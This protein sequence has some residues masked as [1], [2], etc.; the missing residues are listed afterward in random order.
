MIAPPHPGT[1]PTDLRAA[2]GSAVDHYEANGNVA[3]LLQTLFRLCDGAMAD[4]LI[5]AV[6]PWRQM[7]EVAGPV[8]EHI[9]KQQPT[10][11]RAL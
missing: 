11:A 3:A 7:P 1:P 9:V 4:A 5:A 10:N 2:I 6:E 8:Y